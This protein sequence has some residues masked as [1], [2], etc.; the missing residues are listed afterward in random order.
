MTLKLKQRV[1][2]TL[3][4]NNQSMPVCCIKPSH[5]V[6]V[7]SNIRLNHKPISSLAGKD[8]F[9]EPLL[10]IARSEEQARIG[11]VP[12]HIPYNKEAFVGRSDAACGKC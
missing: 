8:T 4:G 5:P 7:D 12:T 6:L 11:V 3:S 1:Y 9:I 10:E 2:Q